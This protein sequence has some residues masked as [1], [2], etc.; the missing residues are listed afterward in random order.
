VIFQRDVL[1]E[2]Q[3]SLEIIYGIAS[4]FSIFRRLLCT[5]ICHSFFGNSLVLKILKFSLLIQINT[6][7][8]ILKIN[9]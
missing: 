3:V 4:C 5:N 1:E 9:L 2:L 8:L 7:C 6:L